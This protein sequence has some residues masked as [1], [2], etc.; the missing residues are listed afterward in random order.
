MCQSS[1][2]PWHLEGWTEQGRLVCGRRYRSGWARPCP[3]GRRLAGRV[4]GSAVARRVAGCL[5][6]LFLCHGA[7]REAR[8]VC[9]GCVQPCPVG[10]SPGG[11]PGKAR[12]DLRTPTG[13]RV[14][15]F[16]GSAGEPVKGWT[17][18]KGD[19]GCRTCPA[20]RR[21]PPGTRNAPGIS[22]RGVPVTFALGRRIS[23][24]SSGC[25]DGSRHP[26]CRPAKRRC[27][28]CR[29]RAPPRAPPRPPCP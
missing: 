25:G 23:P 8:G 15:P 4:C 2:C 11:Q 5:L 9:C 18:R 3:A 14:P 29:T 21:P 28:R 1:G 13:R 22:P 20:P 27:R 24:R 19:G 16:V 26:G 12:P 17:S 6:F 10:A 7:A